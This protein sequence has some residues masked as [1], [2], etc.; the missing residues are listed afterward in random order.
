MCQEAGSPGEAGSPNPYLVLMWHTP[1]PMSPC[2]NVGA[3]RDRR[4]CPCEESLEEQDL[5]GVGQ[6]RRGKG[7]LRLTCMLCSRWLWTCPLQEEEPPP[8]PTLHL[9]HCVYPPGGFPPPRASPGKAAHPHSS[10][11]ALVPW[12]GLWGMSAQRAGSKTPQVRAGLTLS[13]RLDSLSP[14]ACVHQKRSAPLDPIGPAGGG[15][16]A[17][18]S[19]GR[20]SPPP[21]QTSL[22]PCA[23]C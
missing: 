12:G 13:T 3:G 5:R 16:G 15:A 18:H 2:R 17:C 9:L 19:A 21:F 23:A 4:L 6:G 8:P 14:A 1:P 10:V 7:L 11:S 22:Q 20:R